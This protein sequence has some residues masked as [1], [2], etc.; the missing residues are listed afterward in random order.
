[1]K[2]PTLSKIAGTDTKDAL[3]ARLR[4]TFAFCDPALAS[5]NDANL[6]EALPFFGGK[7]MSRAAIMTLTTGDWPDHYSQHA[8][9]LGLNSMLPS[10]GK[11][12]AIQRLAGLPP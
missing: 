12:P 2:A 4:G 5:L 8:N 6:G 9:Y 10:T 7:K 1:M 3:L 11:K